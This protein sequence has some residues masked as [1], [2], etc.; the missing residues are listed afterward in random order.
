MMKLDKS[1]KNQIFGKL[2]IAVI[3]I[4]VLIATLLAKESYKWGLEKGDVSSADIYAPFDFSY[5]DEKSTLELK[6]QRAAEVKPV[7]DFDPG[8]GQKVLADL[9]DFYKSLAQL[10]EGIETEEFTGLTI[11][12]IR[13]ALNSQEAEGIYQKTEQLA[14]FIMLKE[15]SDQIDKKDGFIIVRNTATNADREQDASE[16]LTTKSAGKELLDKAMV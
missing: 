4:T 16:V 3:L 15:I 11:F 1:G 6:A 8:L 14:K 10:P 5:V 9:N 13:A 7:Y 12:E 2:L